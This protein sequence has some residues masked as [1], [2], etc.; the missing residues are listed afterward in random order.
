MSEHQ[1]QLFLTLMNQLQLD[2]EE[3]LQPDFDQALLTKI[4]ITKSIPEWCFNIE[5]NHVIQYEKFKR[6]YEQLK[7]TY[8][9]IAQVKLIVKTREE[10][11]ITQEQIQAYWEMVLFQLQQESPL[12]VQLLSGQIPTWNQKKIQFHCPNEITKSHVNENYIK[13]IQQYFEN[14]GFPKARNLISRI[15]L[16]SIQSD[17]LHSPV[18]MKTHCGALS[19]PDF[20]GC[21]KER[22]I[23]A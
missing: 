13:K 3:F 17:I 10:S 2:N 22:R 11:Q 1:Q 6:F 14:F 5:T 21:S 23:S 7:Q 18:V 15:P 4:D 19:S 16:T 9:K 8:E 20:P 12:V